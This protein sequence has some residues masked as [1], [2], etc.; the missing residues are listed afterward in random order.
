MNRRTGWAYLYALPAFAMYAVFALYP[1]GQTVWISFYKWNGIT[2]GQWVGL[3][4]YTAALTEPRIYTALLHSAVFIVC[5]ALVP[6]A[7]GL[8]L[9]GIFARVRVRGMA[10]FRSVLF[11]PQI[12]ATVVVAV[13][14]RWIYAADGPLNEI[15]RTLGLGRLTHAWLG[16]FGTALP[17]VGLIGTWVEFGLCMVLFI[18]GVQ[19]I[20]QDIFEAARI[21]G[22]GALREFFSIVLPSLRGEI[23]IALILTVAFALRNFDI[24]WNTT[25]GGP[26]D[27]TTVPAYF[28]YQYAFLSRDVGG[29]ATIGVLLTVL[30]LVVIGVIAALLRPG[31]AEA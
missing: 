1:L 29:A 3:S 25:T 8:A 2:A 7:I 4:N 30:I 31:K 19:G 16:D 20:S 22:A 6:V 23:M 9:A 24:V 21:D 28:I 11:L 15:L 17:A 27:S 26:G 18:A 13:T 14:W 10:L 5:Y 12:L